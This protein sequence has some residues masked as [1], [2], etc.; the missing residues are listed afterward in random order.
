MK[1]EQIIKLSKKIREKD[2]QEKKQRIK[3]FNKQINNALNIIAFF[4]ILAGNLGI[5]TFLTHV[6]WSVTDKWCIPEIWA[7]A[8]ILTAVFNVILFSHLYLISFEN[9]E[10]EAKTR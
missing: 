9:K 10:K 6:T 7:Y 1:E 5:L 2:Q 8:L 4:M 3:R